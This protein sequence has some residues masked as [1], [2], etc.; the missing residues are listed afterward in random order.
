VRDTIARRSDVDKDSIKYEV[1]PGTNRYRNGTIRFAAKQGQSIDLKGLHANLKATRL[2]GRTNSGVNHLEITVAGELVAGEKETV[3]KVTG[4]AQQF[5]LAEDPKAAPKEGKKT[6]HQRLQEALKKGDK[7]ASVTGRV[8]GWSGRWPDVLRALEAEE[9]K[10]P[11]KRKP[12]LLF[13]S[14]FQ[15]AKE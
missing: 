9:K 15:V 12:P 14:D 13:V 11:D 6:A 2:G 7:I 4:T 3:L 8:Q 5:V 10:D 1:E